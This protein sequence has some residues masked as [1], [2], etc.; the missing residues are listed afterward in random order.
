[1]GR[2][3]MD[4]VC[5]KVL[6]S[7]PDSNGSSLLCNCHVVCEISLNFHFEFIFIF[8][9]HI[10]SFR[11]SRRNHMCVTFIVAWTSR[12]FIRLLK[13]KET[14]FYCEHDIQ[15]LAGHDPGQQALRGPIKAEDLNQITFSAPLTSAVLWP[16]DSYFPHS[17]IICVQFFSH[18]LQKALSIV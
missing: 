10:L 13:I 8:L 6:C 11:G 15:R 17:P 18:V 14:L 3:N 1:M 16:C 2:F 7:F 12:V 4:L 9:L 5:P